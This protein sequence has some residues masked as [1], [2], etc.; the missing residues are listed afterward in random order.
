MYAPIFNDG[1][2]IDPQPRAFIGCYAEL[3]IA[4]TDSNR[5]GCQEGEVVV[6]C[7]R[8]IVG[9]VFTVGQ[10]RDVG[11]ADNSPQRRIPRKIFEA[12]RRSR[13]IHRHIPSWPASHRW[14]N[15]SVTLWIFEAR[16]RTELSLMVVNFSTSSLLSISPQS[17]IFLASKQV[18][19]LTIS[20]P[21]Y[22]YTLAN[23]HWH[24]GTCVPAS[25]SVCGK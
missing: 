14:V 17:F 19:V 24:T 21:P 16:T 12:S 9:E 20:Y 8:E 1:V 18:V 2:V 13:H 22:I 4:Y 5:S 23:A 10:I 11:I 7:A 6:G 15:L 25:V 3:V